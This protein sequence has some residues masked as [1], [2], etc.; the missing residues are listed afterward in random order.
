MDLLSPWSRESI[1]GQSCQTLQGKCASVHACVFASVWEQVWASACVLWTKFEVPLTGEWLSA[2]ISLQRQ[3]D[4]RMATATHT[5]AKNKHTRTCRTTELGREWESCC[6]LKDAAPD[7][8]LKLAL[9]VW[10][11]HG[12]S[13]RGL[14]AIA[15]GPGRVHV[16]MFP[17]IS[18]HSFTHIRTHA[19]TRTCT[20]TH[21]VSSQRSQ[22]CVTQIL[23]AICQSH[24]KDG[25]HAQTK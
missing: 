5:H 13:H 14:A 16:W 17:S 25:G 18:T 1:K 19:R 8:M 22:S 4:V 11:T 21:Q 15:K 10:I 23:F 9:N 7:Y 20:H 12:S 24:T 6:V 3:W 2:F